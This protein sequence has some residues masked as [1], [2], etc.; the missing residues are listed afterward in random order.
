MNHTTPLY[1]IIIWL[2]PNVEITNMNMK[3]Y[4]KHEDSHNTNIE[5]TV[6]L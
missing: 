3:G 6:T 5:C 4:F 1:Y 2:F